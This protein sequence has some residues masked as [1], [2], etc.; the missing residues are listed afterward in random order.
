MDRNTRSASARGWRPTRREV[1]AA[2]AALPLLPLV[3]GLPGC[4]PSRAR[5]PNI[6]YVLSDSHRASALGCYGNPDVATPHFDA[7]AAEGVRLDCANANTPVCRP[8]RASLMTGC[9][10]STHGMVTNSSPLN[11]GV[12]DV[13]QWRPGELATLGGTLRDA[14]WACGYVGKWHL[15]HVNRAPGDLRFGFD[16]HW[17][18]STYPS[19]TYWDWTYCTGKDEFVEGGGRFRPAMEVDLVLDWLRARRGSPSGAGGAASGGGGAGGDGSAADADER[20]FFCVLSWGPPHDPLEPPAEFMRYAD[21]PLPP[22]VPAGAED[23]ARSV[24]P[25]YYALVEAIDHE[26]GRLLAGLRE[27]GLADDTLVV[28]TSD[29]G[30]MLGSKGLEGKEMPY[31]ESTQVPFLARWPGVLP[32]GTVSPVPFGAPDVFPTLCGLTGTAVPA[33]VQG[34]DL[35]GALRGATDAPTREAVFL[36]A[37]DT[38]LVPHPGWRG[39]RTTDHL[40]AAQE[41]GPW[42]LFDLDADPWQR[43]NLVDDDPALARQFHQRTLDAMARLGD[44][45]RSG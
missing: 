13:G 40:F 8:Y 41:Q 42:L 27:L 30:N 19:H 28:Y 45:W 24:L 12:D 33:S 39:L 36:Q 26:F 22:N 9:H 2:G 43:R 11:F 38:P 37:I 34:L 5:G 44:R 6:L 25:L 21:A 16:D 18:A 17:A 20:P 10:A 15:G 29:H 23:H 32:A 31:R 7:F 1:L 35:S 14:G 3:A 4:S